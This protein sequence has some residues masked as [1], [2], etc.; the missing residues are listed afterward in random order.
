MAA[1]A[2]ADGAG[3]AAGG[4][5][6]T[7]AEALATRNGCRER[8]VKALSEMHTAIC[9]LGVSDIA[10]DLRS[11]ALDD[12]SNMSRYLRE[13]FTTVDRERQAE[14][15]QRIVALWRAGKLVER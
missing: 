12:L 9:A 1:G 10:H 13:G 15:E 8:I 3:A 5:G 11:T 14:E 6:V 4:A 2:D 7:A